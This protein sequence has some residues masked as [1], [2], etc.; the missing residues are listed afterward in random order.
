M[1]NVGVAE[2]SADKA[3]PVLR[4]R[5]SQVKAV[6][7][8]RES[9]YIGQDLVASSCICCAERQAMANELVPAAVAGLC[10]ISGRDLPSILDPKPF[11]L[12]NSVFLH[13]SLLQSPNTPT[14]G[15][16]HAPT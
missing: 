7:T 11:T 5:E 10:H 2:A 16:P 8:Q 13:L 14:Y 6:R 4:A 9:S 15:E 12:L 1:A 3:G